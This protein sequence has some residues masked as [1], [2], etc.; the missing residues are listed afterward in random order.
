M[1]R[2]LLIVFTFLTNAKILNIFRGGDMSKYD[3]EMGSEDPYSLFKDFHKS[4]ANELIKIKE[5][6]DSKVKSPRTWGAEE[7]ASLI[8]RSLSWLRKNDKDAP[9]DSSGRGRWSLERINEW[10]DKLGTR[11]LRPEY[12]TP[13]IYAVINFKG[14]VGKSTCSIHLGQK[15]AIE[16][17]RALVIDLD[18]Q[19]STTYNLGNLIPD[20]DLTE[21]DTL[22]SVF[23]DDLEN[24]KKIIKPTHFENVSI[25]PANLMLQHL[26][27][28]M[29]NPELNELDKL[30]PPATR[31]ARSL[32]HLYKDF[33]VIIMDCPPNMGIL[34]VNALVAANALLMPV[35]PAAFDRASF[36]T[37][38]SSLSDFY[39]QVNKKMKYIR[40]ML[41]KHRGGKADAYHEK[42][43]RALFSHVM[44]NNFYISAEIDKASSQMMSIYDLE[45]PITDTGTYR[46]AVE[47]VDSFFGEIVNDMK[48]IWEKED[49]R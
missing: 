5:F 6:I 9:K 14:G 10:R 8:G 16:G 41:T 31:L 37:F 19:G 27:L 21:E 42:K 46:R 32:K 49:V 17:Y 24:I 26:E 36:V 15:S 4:G 47:I 45:R 28:A 13:M 29:P 7:A 48:L 23:L 34:T 43:I 3:Q 39:K 12:L 2:F 38:C 35:P 1:R 18:P 25:I 40:V 30:G 44:T 20:I 33:D 11:C 22:N